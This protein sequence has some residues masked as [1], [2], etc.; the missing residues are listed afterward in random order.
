MTAGSDKAETEEFTLGNE[1]RISQILARIE[2]ER[3]GFDR[4]IRRTVVVLALTWIP[5]LVL[6]L[7]QGNALGDRVTEPLLHDLETNIRLLVVVPMLILAEFLVGPKL[8]A[9][10]HQFSRS[11]LVPDQEKPALVKVL[12]LTAKL[13]RS[14]VI[15]LLLV[16]LALIAS[17][18]A[19]KY[20]LHDGRSSW[21]TTT[22]GSGRQ[23]TLAG[24]WYGLI[25][26]PIQRFILY[27]WLLRLLLWDWM[28]WRFSRLQLKISPTHPDR[29]GG[30]LFLGY[31]QM[32]FAI[33][34]LA[35]ATI[36]SAHVAERV[37]WGTATLGG[38][39]ALLIGYVVLCVALIVGLLLV[40]SWR[41]WEA[42]L[43]GIDEYGL[44]GDQ[45]VRSFDRKWLREAGKQ[46]EPLLGT[47]DIQSLADLSNSYA[48]IA[49]MK[50]VPVSYR[51]VLTLV[52][53]AVLP[54][55]PLLLFRFSL[56][57]LLLKLLEILK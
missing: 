2:G 56:P 16:S 17:Y 26:G 4:F 54:F 14:I 38:Y 36:A 22:S 6:S 27:R 47:S 18:Q 40:F 55:V 34:I 43:R 49:E 37:L 7:I 42:K 20:G 32:W 33:A 12:R 13:R 53:A 44:L 31:G 30:L 23:L 57:E 45:Y 9:V 48:V 39:R 29:A 8:S 25:S 3:P 15:E 46:E 52:G 35:F 41:L 21:L 5:L 10:V 24:W 28:L 1:G 11:D 50:I 51:V 19:V